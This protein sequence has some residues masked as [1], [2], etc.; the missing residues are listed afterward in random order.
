M[1]TM[2]KEECLKM[3]R[4][5]DVFKKVLSSASTDAE[6]RA[7]KAYAEDFLVK[8]YSN[9]AEPFSKAVASASPADITNAFRKAQGDLIKSG[10][11][12]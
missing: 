9:V 10:S 1:K 2:T 12:G 7:I 3:L 5:N 8:F 11:T 6:R 4:E